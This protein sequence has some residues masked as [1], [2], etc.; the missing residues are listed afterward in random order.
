MDQ[1]IS[2]P[3][4]SPP[5]RRAQAD[6]RLALLDIPTPSSLGRKHST[7][8]ADQIDLTGRVLGVPRVELDHALDLTV[9]SRGDE[10]GD[11]VL[12]C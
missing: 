6:L 3:S 1:A 7:G 9:G 8:V 5:D 10:Q 4:S 11:A 2:Y 12:P